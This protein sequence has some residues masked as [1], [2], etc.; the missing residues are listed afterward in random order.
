MKEKR[1]FCDYWF[2]TGCS[3]KI[4]RLI[5]F[6]SI[7]FITSIGSIISYNVLL[8]KHGNELDSY[9]ESTYQYLDEIAD[10]V[11]QEG[12]GINLLA[13]PEDVVKY[14]ITSQNN[15]VIFKYYLDNNKDLKFAVSA[16]MTVKLSDNFEIV[17]KEP[18][19]TSEEDYIR[20]IKG[21]MIFWSVILGI[22]IWFGVMLVAIIGATIGAFISKA[23]KNKN[24]S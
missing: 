5:M 18:D 24:L 17:S 4:D 21:S 1:Y 10:D 14:E 8:S 6:L 2:G 3:G 15:E 23:N 20:N 11:I 12:T 19:C 16:D 7:I 9:S 22:I 13:L